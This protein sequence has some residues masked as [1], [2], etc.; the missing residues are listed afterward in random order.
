MDK[1]MRM[2]DMTFSEAIVHYQKVVNAYAPLIQRGLLEEYEA[3]DA[4]ELSIMTQRI[5]DIPE[6]DPWPLLNQVM[7]MLFQAVDA[8]ELGAI[9]DIKITIREMVKSK[10][11]AADIRMACFRVSD[12]RLSTAAIDAA[13][14][15]EI[16]AIVKEVQAR[17][18][19]RAG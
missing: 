5:T 17:A 2:R 7:T 10:K 11:P 19:K 6:A 18:I 1:A 13:Y 15:G 9:R 4:L 8:K 14:H 12:G 16:D 3:L